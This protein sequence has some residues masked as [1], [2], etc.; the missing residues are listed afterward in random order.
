MR[1][2]RFAWL[3]AALVVGAPRELA[4][5]VDALSAAFPA[6]ENCLA[7]SASRPL[8]PDCAADCR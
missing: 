3:L 5:C 7:M 2:L 1:S 4:E 8:L 6:D